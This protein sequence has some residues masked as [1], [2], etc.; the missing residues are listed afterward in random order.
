MKR[1]RIQSV[2]CAFICIVFLATTVGGAMVSNAAEEST[3]VA[4]AIVECTGETVSTC[5]TQGMA[6]VFD[7][8]TDRLFAGFYEDSACENPLTKDEIL[9]ATGD[10]KY[11]AKFVAKEVLDVKSQL[12][13]GTMIDSEKTDLCLLSTVDSLHYC[14]VGF[15]VEIGDVQRTLTSTSVYET[16]YGCKDD[17]N[18]TEVLQPEE[19]FSAESAYFMTYK[20]TDFPYTA[21][22]TSI[23]V[24]PQWTTLDG[25]VVTGT[26]KIFTARSIHFA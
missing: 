4:P 14:E 2:F 10:T 13:M 7:G 1:S 18:T 22:D 23:K 12:S 6:P 17:S 5:R 15:K 20:L 9:D 25:I 19:V 24:T 11:F 26:E 16:I 21:Y 3:N 8:M